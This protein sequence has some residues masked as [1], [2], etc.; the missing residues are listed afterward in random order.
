LTFVLLCAV[1][2]VAVAADTNPPP[3]LTV[4]LRD[5]SRV[6][7]QSVE[8]NFKFHSTL[9]GDFKLEVK[10]IRLVECVSTNGAKLTAANGDVMAVQFVAL[11]LRVQTSFGKV[12]LP[13]GS[14]R[15]IMVATAGHPQTARPGL[16]AFWPGNGSADDS[17]GQHNG[18]LVGGANF[19]PGPL[20]QAF[21]FD[22]PGGFVKIPKSSDLN[23]AGQ[24]TIEFWLNAD[25][26][27]SMNN[28]EGLVT[29]DF[30][31]VE[32]SNGYG[33]KMGVNFFLNTGM[34][35]PVPRFGF[36]QGLSGFRSRITSV[37]N[38]THVSDAN[39]S[40]APVA[41]GRWHHVAATYDGAQLRLFIDGQPWGNP[42]SHTGA[43]SPMLPD[44]F[45]AIG[46]EDGRTTCPDC[47][48][49]RY[50]KGLICDVALYSRALSAVEIRE[51]YE[52]GNSN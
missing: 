30:Y 43:I 22:A 4:E 7:G 13:A 29:S 42:M 2:S 35:Q 8:K 11:E 49:Q 48:G 3:R 45:V 5:G 19:A 10:D 38:F 23:P 25:A 12:E 46:S 50:F 20:G 37:A 9:L 6:V 21:N 18:V 1:S 31:G 36:D 15:R 26:A 16:L 34:N 40:D 44:S 33:G 32:I 41:A 17:T 51:D 28:Y 14:I 24:L 39:G 52:A 47:I 27:N